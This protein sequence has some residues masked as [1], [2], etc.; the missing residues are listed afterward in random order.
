M[1]LCRNYKRHVIDENEET[2]MARCNRF[3]SHW[4][5]P[6]YTGGGLSYLFSEVVSCLSYLP[7]FSK[8]QL[9]CYLI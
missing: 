7:V 2:T 3:E 6:L 9:N 8:K 1:S 5:L 4:C